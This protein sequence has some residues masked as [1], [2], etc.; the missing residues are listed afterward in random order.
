[1]AGLLLNPS[2]RCHSDR[3]LWP[4][5]N[6][7]QHAANMQPSAQPSASI[8]ETPESEPRCLWFCLSKRSS[9]I[10]KDVNNICLKAAGEKCTCASK[11][12][13]FQSISSFRCPSRAVAKLCLM[14][15]HVAAMSTGPIVKVLQLPHLNQVLTRRVGDFPISSGLYLPSV[16]TLLLGSYDAHIYSYLLPPLDNPPST[17]L[18]SP[19]PASSAPSAAHMS[20]ACSPQKGQLGALKTVLQAHSN[21]ITCLAYANGQIF[22]GSS[23]GNVKIWMFATRPTYA[24]FQ[25]G[26]GYWRSCDKMRSDQ[27]KDVKNVTLEFLRASV[28]ITEKL[29]TQQSP[30]YSCPC[31]TLEGPQ[32][33]DTVNNSGCGVLPEVAVEGSKELLHSSYLECELPHDSGVTCI[34]VGSV[35][36]HELYREDIWLAVGLKSGTVTIWNCAHTDAPRYTVQGLHCG[37]VTVLC[38]W[39]GEAEAQSQSANTEDDMESVYNTHDYDFTSGNFGRDYSCDE[40]NPQDEWVLVSDA[41][42][43]YYS[44]NSLSPSITTT[45]LGGVKRR[46]KLSAS[47]SRAHYLLTGGV[48]G[49]ATLLDGQLANTATCR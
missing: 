46:A 43:R 7:S 28:D 39:S 48:D 30:A 38:W 32:L 21:P 20:P 16:N 31:L 6:T 47:S 25:T 33:V 13:P 35:Y 15:G 24:G 4:V 26:S 37:E 11:L 41:I 18:N 36:D 2:A 10:Q 8:P 14:E 27:K 23:D 12:R 40:E 22:S 9:S 34:S 5:T 29:S 45:A 44:L 1:M 42:P 17:Q 19:S 3:L 49:R